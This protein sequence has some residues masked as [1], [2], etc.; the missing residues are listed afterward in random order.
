MLSWQARWWV[1]HKNM[2]EIIATG[3]EAW[4]WNQLRMG[5]C[6][7]RKA[8]MIA[9]KALGGRSLT[10][11]APEGREGCAGTGR[12]RGLIL[13][14]VERSGCRIGRFLGVTRMVMV[15]PRRASWWVRSRRGIMCPGA[16]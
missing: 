11:S 15:R 5:V 14:C 6:N 1:H 12:T 8:C 16:G 3:G 7:W 4:V 9:G 10:F 13:A 2:S